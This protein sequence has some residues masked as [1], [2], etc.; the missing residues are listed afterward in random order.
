MIESSS[1]DR[2][3]GS[4]AEVLQ[5]QSA[6]LLALAH[7]AS[8]DQ[9]LLLALKDELQRIRDRAAYLTVDSVV[10]ASEGALRACEEGGVVEAVRRLVDIGRALAGL[11]TV[12]RP[13]VLI[14]DVP[15]DALDGFAE[16][17]AAVLRSAED[18][19]G[20]LDIATQTDPSAF[21]VHHEHL[22]ALVEQRTGRLS[23]VPVYAFGPAGSAAHRQAAAILGARAWFDEPLQL[24]RV[25]RRVRSQVAEAHPLAHRV[26]LCV[27]DDWA[28][29]GLVEALELPALAVFR[30]DS[31]DGLAASLED[32]QPEVIVL[33][34]DTADA[35]LVSLVRTHD[36][37]ADTP[38]I[39][40]S[41]EIGKG[42]ERH[43]SLASVDDILPTDV[44]PG[45]LRTRV[46][47]RARRIRL[48]RRAL[49]TDLRTGCIGRAALLTAADREVRLARRTEQPLTVAFVDID[50][51]RH[52]NRDHGAEAGDRVLMSLARCLRDSFRE[53]DVVGRLASDCFGV[54][55]PSCISAD[56]FR[57]I[58]DTRG[59][60]AL[61][62]EQA[63]HEPLSFS[64]GIA[65][66]RD[67][68]ADVLSRADDALHHARRSGRGHTMVWPL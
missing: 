11:E 53:T 63:G 30:A 29:L 38:V 27:A 15:A 66:T 13:V 6:T 68:V 18:V 45:V 54:L 43:E 58:E 60:F 50:G 46:L 16:E 57:R 12:L 35:A 4:F 9:E 5:G 52:F 34:S 40:I 65:D 49:G 23:A 37:L 14:G 10:H 59:A 67:G 7:E 47:A 17:H 36:L 31:A 24:E 21:V 8:A 62:Q 19:A 33:A 41:D 51:M 1:G 44:A 55:L 64:V 42:A 2:L 48:Y 26:L 56:A 22:E 61:A 39:V 3:R 25:L 28:H 20:G 32:L